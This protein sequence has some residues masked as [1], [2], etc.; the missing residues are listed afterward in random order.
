MWNWKARRYKNLATQQRNYCIS[1]EIRTLAFGPLRRNSMNC[2][3][4]CDSNRFT[5]DQLWNWDD[6]S[7][8]YLVWKLTVSIS[9]K[10]DS[11]SPKMVKKNKIEVLISKAIDFLKPLFS[12]SV[13]ILHFM[14]SFLRYLIFS[15]QL[16]SHTLS[17][18]ACSKKSFTQFYL[19][20][21]CSNWSLHFCYEIN[22]ITYHIFSHMN[23]TLPLDMSSQTKI[24]F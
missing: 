10:N 23:L 8:F 14:Y 17:Q 21:A 7:C 24:I 13:I 15:C 1:L 11:Y 6:V 5:Y 16:F 20:S 19:P 22:H 2:Q 9:W 3:L 12:L 4:V 18:E